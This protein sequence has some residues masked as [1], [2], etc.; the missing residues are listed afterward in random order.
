MI[1]EEIMVRNIND[2]VFR[3]VYYGEI[4]IG[5]GTEEDS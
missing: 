4:Q 2:K 3:H 1:L 5:T